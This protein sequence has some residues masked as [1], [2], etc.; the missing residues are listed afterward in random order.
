MAVQDP[1]GVGEKSRTP[2]PDTSRPPHA[3]FFFV[4]KNQ[5]ETRFLAKNPFFLACARDLKGPTFLARDEFMGKKQ[6]FVPTPVQV[7]GRLEN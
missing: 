7:V 6:I 1:R 4:R 2:C 5:K 3:Q